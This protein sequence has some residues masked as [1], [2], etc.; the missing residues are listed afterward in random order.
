MPATDAA[1]FLAQATSGPTSADIARLSQIGYAA[2]ID[3]QFALPAKSHR[4]FVDAVA[5]NGTAL[6]PAHV[7]ESWWTQVIAG[8][9]QL[10]QRV[11]FALSEIFVV[12]MPA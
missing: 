7:R 5:A 4:A 9:D 8:E 1:R 11:A 6:L 2:W 3:A 12:S 10:R